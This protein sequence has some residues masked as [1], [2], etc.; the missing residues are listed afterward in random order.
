VVAGLNNGT[1]CKHVKPP[2]CPY[3]LVIPVDRGVHGDWDDDEDRR[4][5]FSGTTSSSDLSQLSW[6][7]TSI[8][9]NTSLGLASNEAV[10]DS[11]AVPLGCEDLIDLE[12]GCSEVGTL[13]IPSSRE[14][15]SVRS[16][17][18]DTGESAS[19][20]DAHENSPTERSAS[21]P[22]KETVPE[23]KKPLRVYTHPR[24][25]GRNEKKEL[26]EPK[27]HAKSIGG[28]TEPEHS[29]GTN[30]ATSPCPKT[31]T[32]SSTATRAMRKAK[33][34]R[35]RVRSVGSKKH[36]H[37]MPHEDPYAWP[38]GLP[39]LGLDVHLPSPKGWRERTKP[40]QESPPQADEA[41]LNALLI[42]APPWGFNRLQQ[43]IELTA[44]PSTSAR[45]VAEEVPTFTVVDAI[46]PD[47]PYQQPQ[48]ARLIQPAAPR[49]DSQPMSSHQLVPDLADIQRWIQNTGGAAAFPV[50]GFTGFSGVPP[51]PAAAFTEGPAVS[52]QPHPSGVELGAQGYDTPQ[53]FITASVRDASRE[54]LERD[55]ST[56]RWNSDQSRDPK[57]FDLPARQRSPSLQDFPKQERDIY[58]NI[59]EQLESLVQSLTAE[60]SRMLEDELRSVREKA[61]KNK[62]RERRQR[63]ARRNSHIWGHSSSSFT[64]HSPPHSRDY[65]VP[66]HPPPPRPAPAPGPSSYLSPDAPSPAHYSPYNTA[67]NPTGLYAQHYSHPITSNSSPLSS[68]TST[69]VSGGQNDQEPSRAVAADDEDFVRR[70]ILRT[71]SGITTSIAAGEAPG[72]RH[73]RS[74]GVVASGGIGGV[75]GLADI[76]RSNSSQS[77]EQVEAR[78]SGDPE[79]GVEAPEVGPVWVEALSYPAEESVMIDTRSGTQ[80]SLRPPK[81]PMPL[82]GPPPPPG[83]LPPGHQLDDPS[84]ISSHQSVFEERNFMHLRELDDGSRQSRFIHPH[85]RGADSSSRRDYRSSSVRHGRHGNRER[86]LVLWQSSYSPERR[87]HSTHAHSTHSRGR[88]PRTPSSHSIRDTDYELPETV[89]FAAAP[90]S[91]LIEGPPTLPRQS[92]LP[93]VNYPPPVAFPPGIKAKVVDVYHQSPF[94]FVPRTREVSPNTFFVSILLSTHSS[95][96]EFRVFRIELDKS[97]VDDRALFQTIK[98]TFHELRGW[99]RRFSF[100]GVTDIKFAQVSLPSPLS[101]THGHRQ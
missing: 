41:Q 74:N 59:I 96:S 28:E 50:S 56:A 25:V 4:S 48:L 47:E 92:P 57:D 45:G 3:P 36:A 23:R 84:Q 32:S 38:P 6:D 85:H 11:W 64:S 39:P 20:D 55:S 87:P 62:E 73:R 88:R 2:G 95:G 98:S 67:S 97:E 71:D 77:K 12:M 94:K 53:G 99:R 40:P 10:E 100:K 66:R 17:R 27:K 51:S 21:A 58:S 75:R 7:A 72:L 18:D 68:I 31:P 82:L 15:L 1:W 13:K 63:S 49:Q 14:D 42:P 22:Q 24:S 29:I 80:V 81:I 91:R 5:E 35:A 76:T 70:P 9:S 37:D 8:T 19:T 44:T 79:R 60:T 69:E 46:H 61:R 83:Y 34:D 90:H 93:M 101:V 33:R 16:S 65:R 54:P 30:S 43:A 26:A 89:V 78:S 52:A 86:A